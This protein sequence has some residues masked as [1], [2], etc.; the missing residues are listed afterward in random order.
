[1][2]ISPPFQVVFVAAA[3]FISADRLP[4]PIQEA[5]KTPTP[6]PS[7][8]IKPQPKSKVESATAKKATS[9]LAETNSGFDGT[10]VGEEQKYKGTFD[11][12]IYHPRFIIAGNGTLI[13]RLDGPAAGRFDHVVL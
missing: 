10:W 12:K 7:A 1:M 2:K 8:P 3:L 13:G 4:A 11:G 6:A 5:S 9:T